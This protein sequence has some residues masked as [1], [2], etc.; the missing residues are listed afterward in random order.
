MISFRHK[1]AGLAAFCVV[2]LVAGIAQSNSGKEHLQPSEASRGFEAA[3]YHDF[4]DYIAKRRREISAYRVFFDPQKREQEIDI[5]TPFELKPAN[6]CSAAGP[7]RAVVL[8]HGLS[9]TAFAMR[10][11][12]KAFHKRCFWVRAI[13]LPGHGTRAGDLLDVTYQDWEKSVAFALSGMKSEADELYVG[14]F[15]LGGLLAANAAVMDRDIKGVFAVS[16]ALSV[17]RAWQVKQS[18]WLRHVV[19]W[20]DTDVADDYARYEAMPMNAF[21]QTYLLSKAFGRNVIKAKAQR[22]SLPPVFLV[23]SADDGVINGKQNERFF[24]QDFLAPASRMLIYQRQPT[25]VR[26]IKDGRI[27]YISSDLPDHKVLGFSH[28]GL[29]ISEQNLHYGR[30]GDYRSCG[31]NADRAADQVAR[32]REAK[33]PWRGEVFGMDA[34]TEKQYPEMAR[35]T[36]N[37]LF[38]QM[39]GEIDEFLAHLP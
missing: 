7:R 21:A 29:H 30:Y 10:D 8:I 18:V 6:S 3:L 31:A 39:F 4:K 36:F 26:N 17:E 35:L 27:R 33:N 19:S 9:D 16:P 12:A 1:M 20:A 22:R 14:G 15:S 25:V 32:C 38:E 28:Q 34:A 23:Q 2:L 13:L 11:M 5:V 37:P 24:S